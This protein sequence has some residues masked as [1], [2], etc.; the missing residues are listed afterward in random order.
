MVTP[1]KPKRAAA[2]NKK[3][4][5]RPF[6]PAIVREAQS[7]S[8]RYQ[9]VIRFDEECGE[10]YGRGLE[11]PGAL[12]D[13]RTPDQCVASTR[14]AMEAVAAFMLETGQSPPTP[15]AE[16]SRKIQLNIRVTA[17]EKLIFEQAA[18]STGQGLSDFI[19]AA[20]LVR[21]GLPAPKAAR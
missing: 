19:R 1:K 3:R 14:A 17:D 15:V 2:S 7:L 13:G 11:L 12:G 8:R 18:R 16:G 5:D 6:D 10:Y 20:A 4:L 21:T 9:V